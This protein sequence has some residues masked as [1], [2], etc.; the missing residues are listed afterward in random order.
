M[1]API[2]F[3][4]LGEC[5]NTSLLVQDASGWMWWN[6]SVDGGANNKPPVL[7]QIL[8]SNCW[9]RGRHFIISGFIDWIPACKQTLTDEREFPLK[10]S[11]LL[12][13]INPAVSVGSYTQ[14]AAV[15]RWC[16]CTYTSIPL[17]ESTVQSAMS[18]VLSH[19]VFPLEMCFLPLMRCTAD[20]STRPPGERE[21]A[22]GAINYQPKIEPTPPMPTHLLLEQ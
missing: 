11:R 12:F 22:A 19:S 15:T 7:L 6:C 20:E 18:A 4:C 17:R 14:K 16:M 2:Y 1:K 5:K 8:L 3:S 10:L 9:W 13:L 21:T